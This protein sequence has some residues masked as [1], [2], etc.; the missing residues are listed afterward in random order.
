MLRG[1]LSALPLLGGTIKDCSAPNSVA[2]V[3]SMGINPASPKAGDNSTV[4]VSYEL[5]KEVTGGSVTYSYWVNYIAFTPTTVDL[6]SQEACPLELAVYSSG[7]SIFPDVKGRI[8]GK[9]EWFDQDNQPI[10]C[11]D[12]VYLV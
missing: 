7:S 8:E 10:W 3:E 11:V 5:L 12:T 6:C 1:V 9:I 2:I 4:W